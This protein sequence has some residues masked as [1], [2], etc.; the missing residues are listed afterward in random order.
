MAVASGEQNQR[1]VALVSWMT[2][3]ATR[4]TTGANLALKIA[5]ERTGLVRLHGRMFCPRGAQESAPVIDGVR[6]HRAILQPSG[7]L[8]GG[9]QIR[10]DAPDNIH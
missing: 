5:H 3:S 4:R 7:A 1:T 9:A 8:Q 2:P 10:V 6:M